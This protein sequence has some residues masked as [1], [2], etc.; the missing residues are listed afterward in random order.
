[1][2]TISKAGISNG[3]TIAATHITNIIDALDGTTANN[4]VFAGPV[5]GSAPISASAGFTGSLKGT[6]S[7]ATNATTAA[8]ADSVLFSGINGTSLPASLAGNSYGGVAS[9][10]SVSGQT[11]SNWTASNGGDFTVGQLNYCD[12]S[13]GAVNVLLDAG[14]LNTGAEFTFFWVTG[15]SDIAFSADVSSVIVSENSY[16]KMY[17]T[18]SIVT[19]KFLGN[20][21]YGGVPST[22]VFMLVGSLKA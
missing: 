20:M 17:S 16:K 14:A 9:V 7:W 6:S 12:T 3:N 5:T 15:S 13:K 18:G 2:A 1:M 19:A 8:S 11:K 10:L 22:N 21:N 4:L